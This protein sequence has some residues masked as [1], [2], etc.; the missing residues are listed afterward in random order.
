MPEIWTR[1]L[2]NGNARSHMLLSLSLM[3]IAKHIDAVEHLILAAEELEAIPSSSSFSR[4]VSGVLNTT[5]A[6]N[7][8]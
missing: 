8:L 7:Q 4:R 5:H 6:Q 3:S 1:K 2:R